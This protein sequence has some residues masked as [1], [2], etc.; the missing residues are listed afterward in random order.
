[1][2]NKGCHSCL[3]RC[4]CGYHGLA[5]DCLTRSPGQPLPY[6][7]YVEGDG[8]ELAL[9][10]QREGKINVVVGGTGEAE[11]NALQPIDEAFEEL[12]NI[13]CHCGYIVSRIGTHAIHV[14]NHTE[15]ILVYSADGSRLEK[16]V[17]RN[18]HIHWSFT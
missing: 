8:D 15:R 11:V 18:D 4:T 10:L 6:H 2:S 17:D 1:M 3:Y 5:N 9:Q 13:A 14:Y 16:I 7:K 12:H